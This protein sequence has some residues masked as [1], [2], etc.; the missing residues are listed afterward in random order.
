MT[1]AFVPY[2]FVAARHEAV[3]PPLHDGVDARRHPV[4]VVG[5][6]PVGYCTALGLARHGVPVVLVEADDGVC[7]GSRAICI[8]RRSLEII[9]RLGAL[10]GFLATGLPWSGGRSFYRDAEVLK[11]SMPQDENQKLP[12]MINLAQYSIEHLLLQQV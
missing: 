6:G 4:V 11:F 3:L 7:F 10:P 1:R 2:P 9:E 8:S 12:P 5:A